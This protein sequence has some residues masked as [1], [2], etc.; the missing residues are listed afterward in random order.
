MI[1]GDIG[2]KPIRIKEIS[3]KLSFVRNLITKAE[4]ESS[5]LIDENYISDEGEYLFTDLSKYKDYTYGYRDL[6]I[7]KDAV[8]LMESKYSCHHL[9]LALGLLGPKVSMK[10]VDKGLLIFKCN[11]AITIPAIKSNWEC[12]N[13]HSCDI[14]EMVDI[15]VNEDD[16]YQVYY[17]IGRIRE[18]SI[19]E[20]GMLEHF[21]GRPKES[22]SDFVD[23]V[24]Y[25][26]SK[27]KV[28]FKLI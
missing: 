25:G 14:R 24:E 10:S 12:R 17:T 15:W 26:S 27:G 16:K 1:A 2:E 18:S 11:L 5:I 7:T 8:D 28:T 19:L 22:L 9:R 3:V 13:I 4:L 21:Y 20:H 23:R 6:R